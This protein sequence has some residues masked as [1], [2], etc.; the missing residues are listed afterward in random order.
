ML[1]VEL[2]IEAG[3]ILAEVR[4]RGLLIT[5]GAPKVLRILPPLIATKSDVDDALTTLG[6][7]FSTLA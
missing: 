3:P 7:A 2:S 5:L 1:G 6:E 4:A